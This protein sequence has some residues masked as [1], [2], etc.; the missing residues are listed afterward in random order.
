MCPIK[1]CRWI[2]RGMTPNI[3]LLIATNMR[4]LRKKRKLTQEELAK[5]SDLDYKYLQKLESKH[6]PAMKVDT[7]SKLADAFKV[8]PSK[9]LESKPRRR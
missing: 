9:L 7:V 1:W 3:R 5:R 6:P 8:D 4:L 2:I